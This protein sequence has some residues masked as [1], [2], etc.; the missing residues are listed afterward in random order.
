MLL[1]VPCILE[2][3]RALHFP[4]RCLELQ[5]SGIINLLTITLVRKLADGWWKF[6]AYTCLFA[7]YF[8][9]TL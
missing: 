9:K 5:M 3:S 4:P 6:H 7:L 2:R 1:E 8:C